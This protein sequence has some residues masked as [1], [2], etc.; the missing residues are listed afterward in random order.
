MTMT[1]TMTQSQSQSLTK[2]QIV[3]LDDFADPA[4][5]DTQAA[6][7]AA[8]D[9]YLTRSQDLARLIDQLVAATPPCG[10]ALDLRA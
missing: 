8:L 6:M 4:P 10:P 3:Y 5:G 7:H 1:M 2:S 9:T